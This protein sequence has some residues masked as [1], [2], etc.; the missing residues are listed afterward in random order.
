MSNAVPPAI[1]DLFGWRANGKPNIS[2]GV[3]NPSVRIAATMFEELGV[4]RPTNVPGQ[5]A[6]R[7]FEATIR[8]VLQDRLPQGR[9]WKVGSEK[10]TSFIQ[11]EHLARVNEAAEADPTL[12]S[13][14][15]ADY[16]IKPDIT[17]SLRAG[18]SH[19]LHSRCRANGPSGPI[20]S[21]TYVTRVWY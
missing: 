16:L 12:R 21:R 5:T 11:Y 1:L 8:Q 9:N 19:H 20:A 18:D 4:T 14:L 7:R 3:S 6:G 10:I 15:G 13:S 2:D 17:I